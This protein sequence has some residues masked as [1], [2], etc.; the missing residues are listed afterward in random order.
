M[1]GGAGVPVYLFP[2]APEES[3]WLRR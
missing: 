2:D 1:F 3:R